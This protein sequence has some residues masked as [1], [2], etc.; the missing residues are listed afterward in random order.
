MLAERVAAGQA[1]VV[2]LRYRL[3]DGR[4]EVVAAHGLEAVTA[5]VP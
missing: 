5:A 4:A 3:V 2:G 1:A